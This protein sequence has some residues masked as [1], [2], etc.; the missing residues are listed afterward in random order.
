MRFK[1]V[2]GVVVPLVVIGGVSSY[3][4]YASHRRELIRRLEEWASHSGQVIKG[5]LQHAMLT[6]DW[7]EI[8][9]IVDNVA[10]EEGVQTIFLLNKQ[11]EIRISSDS[12]RV[13]RI[14]DIKDPTCQICHRF[15]PQ[16]RSRSALLVSDTGV[17]I[18][19]S[20]TP[21]ENLSECHRCHDPM[22]RLNGVLIA[23]F[24]TAQLDEQLISDL[25][26]SLLVLGGM[27][28]ALTISISFLMSRMV[29]SRI[30]QLVTGIRLLDSGDYKQRVPVTSEDEIGTLSLT[31]NRMAQGLEEKARLERKVRERTNELQ[32][33]T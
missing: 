32:A 31:F 22:N 23:D 18:F 29:L 24:S 1:V 15:Q 2:V 19:R 10:G 28:A 25:R 14:I 13:G 27:V 11:G 16:M 26:N 7:E 6:Q 30:E 9:G 8:Q 12:D 3:I 21:I 33:Q 5:S 17:R 4:Q 20:V